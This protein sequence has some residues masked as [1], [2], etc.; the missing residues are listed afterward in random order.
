MVDDGRFAEAYD[1]LY[2]LAQVGERIRIPCARDLV[3]ICEHW[4]RV[5]EGKF[6]VSIWPG[7]RHR[8]NCD[9]SEDWPTWVSAAG[10][11]DP[12]LH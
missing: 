4:D 7:C 3:W 1:L 6:C 9:C 12:P 10:S 11:G 5:E 2:Q 8:N